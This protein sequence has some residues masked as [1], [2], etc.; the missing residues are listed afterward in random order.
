MFS[1]PYLLLLSLVILLGLAAC[2]S[3]GFSSKSTSQLSRLDVTGGHLEPAF[4]RGEQSYHLILDDSG[5]P[6]T[7]TVAPAHDLATVTLNGQPLTAGE[8]SPPL[9]VTETP[10]IITIHVV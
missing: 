8:K 1:R 4:S 9:P 2:D 6:L 5:K 10:Y 7:F 3:G